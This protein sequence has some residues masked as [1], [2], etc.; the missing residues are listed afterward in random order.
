MYQTSWLRHVTLP[1]CKNFTK[2]LDFKNRYIHI[3][4]INMINQVMK[5]IVFDLQL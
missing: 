3:F 5:E 2:F 1:S 4:L